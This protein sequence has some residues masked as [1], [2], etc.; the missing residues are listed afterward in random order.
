MRGAHCKGGANLEEVVK[1]K[2]SKWPW[3]GLR[4]LGNIQENSQ[5]GK[6]V[7]NSEGQKE[8]LHLSEREES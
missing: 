3:L 4:Y 1:N 6:Y 5:A 7:H 8:G 2:T